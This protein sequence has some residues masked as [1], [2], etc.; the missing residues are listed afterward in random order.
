MFKVF[1]VVETMKVKQDSSRLEIE[2]LFE[3]V[4]N[5]LYTPKIAA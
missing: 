4:L 2:Q 1:I 5:E 3:S